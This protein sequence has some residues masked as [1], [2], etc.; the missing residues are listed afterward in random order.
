[1]REI[2]SLEKNAT[3]KIVFSIGEYNSK[4]RVDI[5]VFYLDTDS[6]EYKPTKKGIN[7]LTCQFFDFQK[8]IEEVEKELKK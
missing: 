3:E 5:R 4:D 2:T 8:A 7:F 6:N 1:M